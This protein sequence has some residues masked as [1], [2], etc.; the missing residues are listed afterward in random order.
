M[1]PGEAHDSQLFFLLV[2][3]FKLVILLIVDDEPMIA[4]EVRDLVG[5][6]ASQ[7]ADAGSIGPEGR[8]W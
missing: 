6:G 2:E 4:A 3:R 8:P 7:V 5:H 1:L